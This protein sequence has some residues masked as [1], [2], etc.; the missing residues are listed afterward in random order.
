MPQKFCRNYQSPTVRV[1]YFFGV[2][3]FLGLLLF[4]PDPN[5]TS[6]RSFSAPKR[7]KNHLCTTREY[8]RG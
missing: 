1:L 5:A 7:V 2:W 8:E 4:L 6:E 3:K